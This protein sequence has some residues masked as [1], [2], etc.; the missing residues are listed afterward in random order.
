MK[1]YKEYAKA[2]YVCES[3]DSLNEHSI[4]PEQYDLILESLFDLYEDDSDLVIETLIDMQDEGPYLADSFKK[5][6]LPVAESLLDPSDR[7]R[8][9]RT[10]ADKLDRLKD[11][12]LYGKKITN[13]VEH[14]KDN[15]HKATP[16]ERQQGQEDAD[17]PYLTY[18]QRKKAFDKHLK[19]LQ[20]R[21]SPWARN[22]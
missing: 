7:H 13:E 8:K 21:K 1:N 2:K 9:P 5:Y 19:E 12:V 3:F 14:I 10:F 4:T 6:N 22:Q 20:G 17:L 11:L 16:E 18:D 15:L